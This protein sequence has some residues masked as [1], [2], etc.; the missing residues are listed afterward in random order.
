MR[1]GFLVLYVLQRHGRDARRH[2]PSSLQ[3]KKSENGSHYDPQYERFYI[4]DTTRDV[5]DVHYIASHARLNA[6][7]TPSRARTAAI[8]G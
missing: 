1:V 2:G 8:T 5:I 4:C 7:A 6:M 3:H